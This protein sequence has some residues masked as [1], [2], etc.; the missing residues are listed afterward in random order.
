MQQA[1]SYTILGI[2]PNGIRAYLKN[3]AH[4]VTNFCS[5]YNP[6][7]ILFNETKGNQEKHDKEIVPLA[8]KTLPGYFWIW[9]HGLRPGYAGT[10]IAYKPNIQIKNVDYG[11]GTGEKEPEGRLITLELENCYIVGLYS[12]NAGSNRLDYKIVWL[13]KLISY[14]EKLKATGNVVIAFGDWNVAPQ[15]IDIHDPINLKDCAGFTIEERT[16]FANMLKL[17][18]ID[19]FRYLNPHQVAYTFFSGRSKK[20]GGWRIDHIIADTNSIQS[21]KLRFEYFDI[22]TQDRGSDHVPIVSKFFIDKR[23]YKLPIL[24]QI[25]DNHGIFLSIDTDPLWKNPFQLNKTEKKDKAQ[26][27]NSLLKYDTYIRQK[28]SQEINVFQPL[29]LKLVTE[30]Y[31]LVCKCRRGCHGKIILKILEEFIIY[32]KQ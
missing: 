15:P 11:F 9:N 18:W 22:L 5:R 25:G 2:N 14:L 12:V 6:D 10:A 26:R 23:E 31:C 29:M 17:G 27:Q 16:C 20:Q 19:V 30:S 8:N 3:A 7:I 21:G 28:I 24:N 32:L 1:Y 13:T 4:E